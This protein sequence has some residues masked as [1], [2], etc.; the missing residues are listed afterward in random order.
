MPT[1]DILVIP[2]EKVVI[3]SAPTSPTNSETG[4]AGV[5]L[6]PLYMSHP[7]HKVMKDE[8]KRAVSSQ[9][10]DNR[11]LYPRVVSLLMYPPGIPGWYI[12]LLP[13]YRTGTTWP[14]CT[15]IMPDSCKNDTSVR[16]PVRERVPL[17]RVL[18]LSH[19]NKPSFL[20][21]TGRK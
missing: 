21:E 3:S 13:V 16:H 2:A 6:Y 10:G 14:A 19:E 11:G 15:L 17:R 20:G 8:K 18:P 9:K 5:L 1:F 4:D 12:R 7:E